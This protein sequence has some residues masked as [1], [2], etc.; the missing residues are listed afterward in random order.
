PTG[1]CLVTLDGGG[2]PSYDL[3]G[4]VAYDHIAGDPAGETFDALYF[5][6]L[7]L[8]GGENMRSLEKIIKNNVFGEIFVDVNIR[9]PFYSRESILFALDHAT[10]IK[11]SD[12]ELPIVTREMFGA[13]PPFS[14]A[15]K[16]I[17]ERFKN[18]K[19]IVITRGERGAFAYDARS[20]R[21]YYADAEKVDV[22]STVGAG[23]SFSAAF[24]YSYL[25]GE[26]VETCLSRA[27]KLA[28]L[29]V[30]HA[31]AIPDY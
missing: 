31:D 20:K 15:A 25:S 3:L 24:M 21:T 30:S 16:M 27:G 22:V 6:T 5:G 29:V 19:M 13:E 10:V 11:I 12:E 14:D 2:K 7:A 9:P 26:S 18:V 23:D 28:A 8:R 1:K 17:A 4:D